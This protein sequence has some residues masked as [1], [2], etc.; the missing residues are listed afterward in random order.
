M[1]NATKVILFAVG[2]AVPRLPAFATKSCLPSPCET[3]GGAFDAVKC[4]TVADWIATGTITRIVHHQ[5]EEPLYKDFAEFTFTARRRAKAMSMPP[6]A[7]LK[8]EAAACE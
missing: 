2:V 8:T 5:Q 7:S 6:D 3:G 1:R 4:K